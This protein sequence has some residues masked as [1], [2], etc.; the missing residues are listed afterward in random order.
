MS[1]PK[2][3]LDQAFDL[4]RAGRN[5]EAIEIL[6]GL[7]AEDDPDA[8]WI[9][10]DVYWRGQLVPA[11][12]ARGLDYMRRSA[13]RGHPT[14]TRAYT[15]L[16]GNGAAGP[17]DWPKALARLATEAREDGRRAQMLALIGRMD[18]DAEGNPRTV[19]KPQI[20]SESPSIHLF[21]NLFTPAECDYLVAV[22]EPTFEPSLVADPAGDRPDPIRTSDSS[23]M[24]WLIEDPAIHALNR[25]IA[26]VSGTA[27]EQGEPL[28]ILRYSPGQQYR[29]HL[30]YVPG[31]ANQRVKTALVYLNTGYEG[32]QTEFVKAGLMVNARKGNGIVFRNILADGRAD[33]MS[34]HAGL[35]VTRGVK[36]LASRWIHER[37]HVA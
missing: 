30:D 28:L 1:S 4:S 2:P 5:D 27:W 6:D 18:L 10:G 11:D 21:P 13:G 14:A 32:G 12:A 35:P 37:R 33:P 20:V 3:T 24:H 31:L 17:R 22:A 15:N 16:L 36:Y 23:A 34:E 7:A 25:R 26:A 9:L 8:L 19:P 29:N